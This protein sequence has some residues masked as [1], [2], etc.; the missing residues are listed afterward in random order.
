M[1]T[2]LN[3]SERRLYSTTSGLAEHAVTDLK[4]RILKEIAA[5]GDP[6]LVRARLV[7][8]RIKSP[9][10]LIRKAKQR[11]WT[12]K[13]ALTKAQ[14]I[15]GLRVVCHN[16][17]DVQRVANLL[18]KSLQ[19]DGLDVTRHDYVIKPLSTGY[20]A[21]H[22][23]FSMRVALGSNEADIGCEIQI[24]SLLQDSWAELSRADIYA[25][26]LPLPASIEQRMKKLSK[27]LARAD[28]T[29]D[30]I[31]KDIV[32]PH[33][34]RRPTSGQPLTATAV[35]FLFHDCFG[36]EPPDY[37]VRS[38]IRATEAL[39]LRSDG[40]H[41]ALTDQAFMLR[42]KV[43]YE[44]AIGWAPENAQLFDWAVQS[45]HLG[46]NAAVRQAARDGRAERLE[47]ESIARREMLSGVSSVDDMLKSLDHAQK[48]GD[49]DSDIEMWASAL[50]VSTGCA[51]CGTAI[52]NPDEFASAAVRHYGV[53]RKYKEPLGEQLADAVRST[54]IEIGSW[55]SSS[56]CSHCADV[57]DKD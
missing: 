35:A 57:L 49:P 56:I 41:V 4:G 17:Q 30:K 12:F 46:K 2:V 13:E 53:Q 55:D 6:N 43:A 9:S 19:Q 48:D 31:R 34:G 21:I 45:L 23:V 3:D 18:E 32:R 51:F 37:L 26:D 39:E 40:L 22:L 14:D 25:G 15:V 29:A 27:L 42:L 28:A 33:R 54:A 11:R 52:V 5:L 44:E 20:R 7:D 1:S 16:L 8:P 38:V 50:G 24:R 10:S 36:Q 47:I